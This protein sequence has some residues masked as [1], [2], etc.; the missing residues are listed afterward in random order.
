M[1]STVFYKCNK[2]T[3]FLNPFNLKKIDMKTKLLLL[4]MLLGIITISCKKETEENEN[5][6][7]EAKYY[8]EVDGAKTQIDTCYDIYYSDYW[9]NYYHYYVLVSKDVYY[10]SFMKDL[11]GKGDGFAMK[12]QSDNNSLISAGN[13]ALDSTNTT[14]GPGMV[15]KARYC[16]DYDYFMNDGDKINMKSGNI[17]LIDAGS[18]NIFEVKGTFLGKDKKEYKVYYK[19]GIT[20]GYSNYF[21]I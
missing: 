9:G 4:I 21:D 6:V 16:I 5:T 8:V 14:P 20:K 11:L 19:G 7:V 2:K 10:D 12:F 3:K 1:V 15:V 13:Y 17:E 18:N